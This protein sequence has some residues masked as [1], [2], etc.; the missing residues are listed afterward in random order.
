MSSRKQQF[1]N[2]YLVLSNDLDRLKFLQILNAVQADAMFVEHQKRLRVVMFENET[3]HS[4]HFQLLLAVD[5]SVPTRTPSLHHR[6]W[7]HRVSLF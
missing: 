5:D 1:E 7:V 2:C 4:K 3:H 6:N